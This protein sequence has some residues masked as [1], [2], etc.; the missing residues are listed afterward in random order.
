MKENRDKSKE[1]EEATYG[2]RCEGGGIKWRRGDLIEG[3][4]YQSEICQSV[5]SPSTQSPR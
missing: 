5:P 1:K 3:C 4:C 2:K